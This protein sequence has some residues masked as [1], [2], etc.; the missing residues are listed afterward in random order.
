MPLA[1]VDNAEIAGDGS[2]RTRGDA[3]AGLWQG[4]GMS[5]SRSVAAP[6][7]ALY[8]PVKALLAGQ[9]YDVKGEIAGCDV[10]G[11]RGD[12]PPIIVE[13]KRRFGLDL[14]LQGIDRLSLTDAVYLAVGTWPGDPA[15]ARRLCRRVG[16]G[17][18]IVVDGRA[19][20]LLDPVPYRPRRKPARTARLLREHQCRVGDPSPGGV[21]RQPIMT[22][23]R[24]EAIRCLRLLAGG[25]ASPRALRATGTVPHAAGI[26]QRDVYGWFERV[27]RG[28]YRLSPRGEAA[29][30]GIGARSSGD[31]MNISGGHPPLVSAE[32]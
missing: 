6:E 1:A 27:E 21:A 25:P 30:A 26:L 31:G 9:G 2:R 22:A 4:V 13:L 23:Y 8:A 24:Q 14:V 5:S 29:L 3:G 11:V 17:L 7:S 16:L 19:E 28:V 32:D 15:G 20:V 18:I 10:V 12:E